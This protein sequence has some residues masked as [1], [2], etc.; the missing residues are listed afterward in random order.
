MHVTEKWPNEVIPLTFFFAPRLGGLAKGARVTEVTG[1]TVTPD[2]DSLD[3]SI[4]APHEAVIDPVTEMAVQV[5]AEKG[6]SQRIYQ[7]SCTA[8]VVHAG[9]PYTFTIVLPV[10]V[11]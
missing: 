9:N 5:V 11:R 6:I 8:G 10:K 7:V 4:G 1:L 2:D 3:L